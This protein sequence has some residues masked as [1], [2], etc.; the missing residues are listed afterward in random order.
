[1]HA[2]LRD[3]TVPVGGG[4]VQVRDIDPTRLDAAVG[5]VRGGKAGSL[6]QGLGA[7][8][9]SSEA[10]GSFGGVG[11]GAASAPLGRD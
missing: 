10:A 4:R 1:M 2:A 7:T 11:G 8:D 6:V 9:E 5:A 3:G